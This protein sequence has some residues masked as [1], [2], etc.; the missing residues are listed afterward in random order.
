MAT[1]A[2]L[3]LCSAG[4]AGAQS[5]EQLDRDLTRLVNDYT[6]L[7]TKDTFDKWRM[8][9]L[10]SFTVASTTAEGGVST[11]NLEQFLAAQEKGFAERSRM[12]ERLENV[13]ID[14]RGRI[15]TVRADFVFWY[16][17]ETSRGKLALLAIA[18]QKGWR[19][20]SLAFTYHD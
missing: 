8:L 4:V 18:D 14:R 7:Y 1:I 13:A 2:L 10:P 3:G 20:Q 5:P 16:N 9:F 19:F 6:G 15:A 17:D 11:R 12:G